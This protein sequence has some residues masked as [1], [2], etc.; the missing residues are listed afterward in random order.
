MLF[1][2]GLWEFGAALRPSQRSPRHERTE[3]PSLEKQ[4]RD[5]VPT[6]VVTRSAEYC[7]RPRTPT[8]PATGGIFPYLLASTPSC[9]VRGIDCEFC[10]AAIADADETTRDGHGSR[11]SRYVGRSVGTHGGCCG[12]PKRDNYLQNFAGACRVVPRAF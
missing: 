2:L 6:P 3:G 11:P 9:L 4:R 7:R 8:N 1:I 10:P 12:P 5:G